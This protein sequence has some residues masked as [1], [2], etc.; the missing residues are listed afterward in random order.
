MRPSL[1]VE[2]TLKAFGN[3]L[4]VARLR[5]RLPQSSIAARAGISLN[6]L[7]KIEAGDPGV[8]IGNVF[9][10]MSAIGLDIT[11]LSETVSPANDLNGLKMESER[12][13]QRART[14]KQIF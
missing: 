13:P 12:L 7:S 3:N 1:S 9:S 11:Q 8:S 5:R 10:V 14:P 2:T 6:T 4:K